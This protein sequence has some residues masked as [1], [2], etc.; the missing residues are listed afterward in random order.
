MKSKTYKTV[1][2]DSK[3]RIAL[4]KIAEGVSS[5]RVTTDSQHR[6]I[7]EPQVEIPAQEKWLFENEVALS[8]V[9]KGLQDSAAGRTKYLGSFEQYLEEDEEKK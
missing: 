5:Y 9:K 6:I 3:G 8:R 7:L 2:P 1:R 4:G